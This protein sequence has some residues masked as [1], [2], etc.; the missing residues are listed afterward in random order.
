MTISR[1]DIL[2]TMCSIEHGDAV[3]TIAIFTNFIGR[4]QVVG[5]NL[6]PF[7]WLS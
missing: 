4:E 5:Y 3:Q 7:I 2:N 1:K 6:L